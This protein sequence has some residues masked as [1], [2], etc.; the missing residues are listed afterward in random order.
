MAV[1]AAVVGVDVVVLTPVTEEVSGAVVEV[2]EEV[3]EVVEVED[4]VEEV[5]VEVEEV[6]EEVLELEVLEDEIVEVVSYWGPA[7]KSTTGSVALS[8]EA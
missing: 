5:L 3:V 1:E 8:A 2:V 7:S 6:V 4:V